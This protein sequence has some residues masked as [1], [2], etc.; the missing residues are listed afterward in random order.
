MILISVLYQNPR[1]LEPNPQG[2]ISSNTSKMN[3]KLKE[4]N[5]ILHENFTFLLHF[6]IRP[7]IDH[8]TLQ[9]KEMSDW[10]MM[11][12]DFEISNFKVKSHFSKNIKQRIFHRFLVHDFAIFDR[13]KEDQEKTYIENNPCPLAPHLRSKKHERLSVH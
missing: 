12:L 2:L 5:A 6:L 7:D 1:I 11:P 8:K 3:H 10:Q 9:Y 13:L 4:Y